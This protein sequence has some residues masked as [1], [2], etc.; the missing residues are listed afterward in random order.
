M[1]CA[2]SGQ[3][4]ILFEMVEAANLRFNNIHALCDLNT[5]ATRWV[6][7]SPVFTLDDPAPYLFN[8]NKAALMKMVGQTLETFVLIGDRRLLNGHHHSPMGILAK[9]IKRELEEANSQPTG[10]SSAAAS[11]LL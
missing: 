3:A 7:F 5:Q 11:C 4:S 9:F 2:T 8:E 1:V 6:L 10:Q